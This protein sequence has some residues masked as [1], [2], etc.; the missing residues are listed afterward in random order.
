MPKITDPEKRHSN[1]ILTS[2][3]ATEKAD[4]E[5]TEVPAHSIY[6][7]SF[8]ETLV[9][10]AVHSRT[11]YSINKEIPSESQ[12]NWNK[13]YLADGK[14]VE[15]LFLQYTNTWLSELNRFESLIF[16]SVKVRVECQP[17]LCK[18][19]VEDHKN[20]DQKCVHS[21]IAILFS[22]GLDST[23]LAAL[24]DRVWPAEEPIDLLNVAFSAP[25][26]PAN[27]KNASSKEKS[28]ENFN[29][30]DRLT[31]LQA[32]VELQ[33]LNPSRQWNFVKVLK[34]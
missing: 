33:T 16:E 22:G 27:H 20:D 29:V 24:T 1:L 8:S 10:E 5:L 19:C 14:N 17:M 21:K 12:L 32:L 4:A 7:I 13:D 23:V 18:K 2:A 9:I 11:T 34:S 6:Q 3:T 15:H 26:K 30:P 28:A 25:T 31:G